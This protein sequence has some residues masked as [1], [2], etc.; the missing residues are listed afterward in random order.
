MNMRHCLLVYLRV[1]SFIHAYV[2]RKLG[3]DLDE[4]FKV[5]TAKR[6]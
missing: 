6:S 5:N 4:I 2:R 3:T 1:Y